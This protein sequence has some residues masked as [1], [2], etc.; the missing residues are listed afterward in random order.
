MSEEDLSDG[1]NEDDGDEGGVGDGFA[2]VISKILSQNVNGKIPVLAKRKTSKMKEIE[3]MKD[4][5]EQQKKLRTER[6]AEREKQVVIPT[7][8]T[9]DYERQLKKLATRG[10][11]IFMSNSF[12]YSSPVF[13]F[14]F[15]IAVIT[16]HSCG[17]F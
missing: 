17:T 9:L 15:L 3:A 13:F 4:E 12:I 2:N 16:T 11:L 6:K 5:K 1:R 14:M 10:G 7:V 8:I